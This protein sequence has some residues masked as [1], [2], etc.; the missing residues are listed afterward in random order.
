[1]S[2]SF[3]RRSAAGAV[4]AVLLA[5]GLA[6]TGHFSAAAQNSPPIKIGFSMAL[7]GPLA[8]NGKQALLG[9]K[10]WAEDVNAKG[11]LLGRKVELVNYDDQSNPSTIPG[12]Y[13]KLLDV[14]KVDLVVSGYATNMVAPA[15]PVVMQKN[16]TFISL[17]AL[18]ANSEFHYPRYF[19]ML[20]SGPT[21]KES[22]TEGF[23][24]VAAAQNPKPKTIALAA[25]DAEFSRN[26]C[27]G[28]RNNVK[29]Y[30]FDI[31]YDKTYPPNTT[32]FS[33]IVRA[34][35]AANPDL[36]VFCSYPLS[37]VGLV[38][39]VTEL[40]FKPK[41]WGGAMVGL[42]ALAFKD[43]LK[44]KLNGIVNYETWVPSPK[45]L[46]PA[47]DFFKKYQAR[48]ASEGVDPL[49]YYLGGWGYAYFQVLQQ[50]VEGTKSIDDAKLADYL[51]SHEFKT[52]MADVK[53]G[54]DGEWT[55]SGMLQVQY[56]DLTDA[57]NLDTWRGMS[58]QTVLTPADEKTGNVIYPYE[59][60]LK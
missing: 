20:P 13:T 42:Q 28:A 47:A 34:I 22:F 57:A 40:G 5:A 37:S 2:F 51:K 4:G 18:A 30:G 27:E 8:A 1:M 23:F 56:H 19:S 58:Y 31:V 6:A 12:I 38:Q 60:A 44:G 26:A 54:K 35:Q 21:P 32:D 15:I 17:F 48:A 14:D 9:A 55:K 41:M 16:K 46:A 11:G 53:F 24:E 43:K 25:E 36:V 59:K 45:L 50:A 49:G 3:S 10:I 7:T 39:S 33:P 52:I 29:K